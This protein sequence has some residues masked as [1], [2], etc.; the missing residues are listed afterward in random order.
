MAHARHFQEGETDKE[1]KDGKGNG[2]DGG[3]MDSGSDR[4]AAFET[5]AAI[6]TFQEDP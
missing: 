4:T 6:R 5:R 1:G 3:Q 2:N